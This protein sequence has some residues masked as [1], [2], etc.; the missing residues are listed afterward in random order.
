MR[1]RFPEGFKLIATVLST[2]YLTAC[3]ITGYDTQKHGIRDTQ[4]RDTIHRVHGIR[5]TKKMFEMT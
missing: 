3:K 5:D 4:A 2:G 1:P